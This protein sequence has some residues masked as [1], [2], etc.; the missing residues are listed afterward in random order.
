MSLIE[1][2]SLRRSLLAIERRR[3]AISGS[4]TP[5][6]RVKG[7]RSLT[8]WLCTNALIGLELVDDPFA[9]ERQ[10]LSEYA[11][12]LNLTL[13][14]REPFARSMLEMRRD[15]L[16]RRGGSQVRKFRSR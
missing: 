16:H 1:A 13:R 14:R 15:A 10:L 8:R 11:S 6:C 2:S 12:P 3:K 5:A 4:A 9:R 7:E